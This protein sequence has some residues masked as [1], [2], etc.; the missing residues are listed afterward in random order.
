MT[1]DEEYRLYQTFEYNMQLVV[2]DGIPLE[3]LPSP[4][5]CLDELSPSTRA[6]L[7]Q[8]YEKL[9]RELTRMKLEGRF[10]DA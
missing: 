5:L 4:G 9:C 8:M 7:H 2:V 10:N 3:F 1:P 6:R